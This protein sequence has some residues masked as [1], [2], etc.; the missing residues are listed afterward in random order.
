MLTTFVVVRSKKRLKRLQMAPS[1]SIGLS[2]LSQNQPPISVL[3]QSDDDISLNDL[4]QNQPSTSA[5]QQFDDDID[6][7]ASNSSNEKINNHETPFDGSWVVVE[8]MSRKT[9]IHFVGKIVNGD[10][11]LGWEVKFLQKSTKSFIFPKVP[12][13][14]VISPK[15]VMKVLQPPLVKNEVSMCLMKIFPGSILVNY[16]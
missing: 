13:I 10:N 1:T 6:S 8:Y 16:R 2:D 3:Q 7:N 9:K 12:D 14:D 15:A 4:H 11:Q 5:L